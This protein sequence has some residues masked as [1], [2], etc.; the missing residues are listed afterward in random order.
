MKSST[1]KWLIAAVVLTFSGLIIC[2]TAFLTSGFDITRFNAQKDLKKTDYS[3][4]RNGAEDISIEA[5]DS[6]VRI[7]KSKD[8]DQEAIK[9]TCYENESFM[10]EIGNNDNCLRI[11]ER[12][13]RKWYNRIFNLNFEENELTVIIPEKDW[14]D[15]KVTTSSGDVNV[16]GLNFDSVIFDTSSG[17]IKAKNTSASRKLSLTSTS[18]DVLAENCTA[19]DVILQS[20]SGDLST[21]K[22][23]AYNKVSLECTSGDIEATELS[24][25]NDLNVKSTSG[26]ISFTDTV[27]KNKFVSDCT[28]GDTVFIKLSAKSL[29]AGSLSGD[30]DFSK[31]TAE[32]YTLNSTSG[33]ITGTVNESEDTVTFFTNS[34]SGNI[35][36][37]HPSKG[38]NVFTASTSSGDI[39]IKFS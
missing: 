32:E 30:I 7:I 1:K 39:D 36:V 12:D 4:S 10:Y 16:D 8:N 26:D 20:T 19:K 22:V 18:G 21:E 33:D 9:I 15:I 14:K 31:L 11:Y 38:N 25:G 6:D 27:C 13:T 28:S 5:S 37:P 24:V 23:T 35:S 3:I 17:N 34:H 29:T 2:F